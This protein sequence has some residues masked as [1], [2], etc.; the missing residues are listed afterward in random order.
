MSLQGETKK[1][2]GGR[3]HW[4][5]RACDCRACVRKTVHRKVAVHDHTTIS[6]VTRQKAIK[7]SESD[8]NMVAC[9]A[10][11]LSEVFQNM[12]GSSIPMENS[13]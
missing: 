2:S 1:P 13:S 5:K 8:C 11:P 10:C 3:K 6:T 12:R 4:Q 7:S 9:A